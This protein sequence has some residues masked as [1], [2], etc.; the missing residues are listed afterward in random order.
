MQHFDVSREFL[1]T[2][3]QYDADREVYI[4]DYL[5]GSASSKVVGAKENSGVLAL[6]FEYYS[7]IDDATVIRT[8]TLSIQ[9]N[10]T[11]YKYL[12]CESVAVDSI[13]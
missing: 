1:K 13:E 6:D 10:T 5:G 4:L 3:K 9:T 11:P 7:P 12:S 2:S 8:G